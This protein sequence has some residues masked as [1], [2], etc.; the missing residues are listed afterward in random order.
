[1]MSA[2]GQSRR[3]TNVC[4]PMFT[5][6]SGLAA[7]HNITDFIFINPVSSANRGLV[8][9]TREDAKTRRNILPEAALQAGY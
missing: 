7:P 6:K 1:M 9:V 2:P 4:F 8:I 5:P 3:W